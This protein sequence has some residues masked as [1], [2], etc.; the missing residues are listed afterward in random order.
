M[1]TVSIEV[2]E[3]ESN[4][5]NEIAANLEVDRTEVLRAAIEEYLA[6]YRQELAVSAEADREFES[7]K[8]LSHEEIMARHEVWKASL[9]NGQKAA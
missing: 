7:G 8:T 5:L 9:L 2:T 4:T 3:E 1:A 6:G